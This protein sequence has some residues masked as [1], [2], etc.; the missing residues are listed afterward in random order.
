MANNVQE[1]KGKVQDAA[2]KTADAARDLGNEAAQK[3]RDIGHDLADAGRS[4]AS[5][6][7]KAVDQAT[8]K[9][10]EG[11][12]SLGD[13][14]REYGPKQGY[15]GQA[16]ETVANSIE[17][18]GQYLK[19]EGFSGMANDLTEMVKRN[20]LPALLFGIGV[21]FILARLTSSRS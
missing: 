5:A 13:K 9:T 16:A 2:G 1:A 4:A 14:V 17:K 7:G 8:S 6:A 18:T 12:E 19:D 11:I 15:A 3:A 10:G 20:P 21:G